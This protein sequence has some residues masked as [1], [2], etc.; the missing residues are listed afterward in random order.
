MSDDQ[1]GAATARGDTVHPLAEQRDVARE[2]RKTLEES[3]AWNAITAN[4]PIKWNNNTVYC[5]GEALPQTYQRLFHLAA[6]ILSGR[7]VVRGTGHGRFVAVIS[8][9]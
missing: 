8:E 6:T 1:K 7:F 9:A 3:N 2:A 5:D 4:L